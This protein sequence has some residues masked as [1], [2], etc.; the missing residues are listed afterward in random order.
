MVGSIVTGQESQD[1]DF[2]TC[3][4][5]PGNLVDCTK[6]LD[7]NDCENPI[8]GT[9]ISPY[10]P[11]PMQDNDLWGTV[12]HNILNIV[13]LFYMI[14]SLLLVQT[15]HQKLSEFDHHIDTE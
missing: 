10:Y 1:V 14:S 15:H 6:T 2:V 13:E 5:N 9:I 3:E 4:L 7:F 8:T 12:Y 11:Y